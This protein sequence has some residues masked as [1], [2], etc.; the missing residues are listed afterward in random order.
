MMYFHNLKKTKA[1][2]GS[3]TA[4][5]YTLWCLFFFYQG[6]AIELATATEEVLSL[7]MSTL[8]Y[9]ILLK[10][11]V[12][13]CDILHQYITE[14][15]KNRAMQSTWEKK[16]P[17][18]VYKDTEAK[19]NL[20]YLL[21]FDYMPNLFELECHLITN[22]IM[23][24][25]VLL[26]SLGLFYITHFIWGALALL[27]VFSLNYL[28]KNICIKAIDQQQKALNQHKRHLSHWMHQFF[29]AYREVS[30][31]WPFDV[32]KT[33][34]KTMYQKLFLTQKKMTQLHLYRDLLSQALVEL[35]FLVN[36]AGVILALYQHYLSVTQLFVWIGVSQFAIQASNA[37]LENKLYRKKRTTLTHEAQH[38]LQT[39]G[40]KPPCAH[41]KKTPALP[42]INITLQDGT[43]N[44]LALKPG[45]Y[46]I[47][48]KNG[49]GK[50]TLL[51]LVLGYERQLK[52]P[53]YHPLKHL[54]ASVHPQS[55]RVIERDAVVFDCINSFEAQVFGP[56]PHKNTSWE[57]VITHRVTPLL[58]VSLTYQ[59]LDLF[60]TLE[61]RYNQRLDKSFSSGERVML[62]FMRCLLSWSNQ[63]KILVIDECEAFLAP[64]VKQHFVQSIDKLSQKTAIFMSSH[65]LTLMPHVW[66]Q[67]D[68]AN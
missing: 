2:L 56:T 32:L 31:N 6:R 47:T 66:K 22:R 28:S 63:I 53:A 50:S 23:M 3:L 36:T 43:Q 65:Q 13:S 49:A 12:I 67:H 1:L 24:W 35:P 60:R 5:K 37:Y 55:I 51:N 64:D 8:L 29:S 38:I 26:V 14:Q 21:F 68:I 27:L 9:F 39:L 40:Y 52:S 19:H 34:P 58:G 17:S 61:A 11:G 30:K 16:F 33:W 44:Q 45:L 57:H 62:S 20:M 54:L 18:H 4:L 15:E 7:L 41:A 48:G 59:W 10:V 46:P 42:A 25:S